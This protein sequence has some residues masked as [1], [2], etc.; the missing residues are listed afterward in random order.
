VA[1]NRRPVTPDQK[2]RDLQRD[3]RTLQKE[4]PGP[5]RAEALAT[6]ARA[7]HVDRQ[8]NLAMLAAQQC[9]DEDPSQPDLLVAAYR[10]GAPGE[11]RLEE[12][13]DLRDLAR[14]LERGD[15]VELADRDL[16]SAARE[17]VVA[18]EDGERR[19]RLR[20]VQSLGSRALADTLRDEL[21]EM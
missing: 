4:D 14:Y 15:L 2:S 10:A 13:A 3:F 12:L 1:A 16:E 9:L 6:L 7:A 5:D 18:A 20:T 21:D 17:W 19:Y 11:A 8:L